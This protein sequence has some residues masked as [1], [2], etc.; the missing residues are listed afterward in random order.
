MRDTLYITM[1]ANKFVKKIKM[2]NYK[3]VILEIQMDQDV[4]FV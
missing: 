2:K 1:M 4:K 3:V